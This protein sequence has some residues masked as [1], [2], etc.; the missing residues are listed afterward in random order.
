MDSLVEEQRRAITMKSSSIALHHRGHS[1]TVIDSPGH[2]DF[3]SEVSTVASLSDGALILVDA[4]EGV[5]IQ[6]HAVL[7]QAWID[8]LTQCLVINKID[9]LIS[10]LAMSPSEVYV[11]LLR[12]VSEVN[13]IVSGFKSV[14]YLNDVDGIVSGPSGA[15]DVAFQEI[16]DDEELMFQP[17]KG[18]VAFKALWGPWYFNH[19][20]RKIVGENGVAGLRMARPMFVEFVLEPVWSLYQVAWK[21]REEAEAMG[22]VKAVMSHW[23]PVHEAILSMVI[24][25][26]PDPI[27]AQLYRISRL[28]PKRAEDDSSVPSR[29]ELVRRSLKLVILGLK[30]LVLLLFRK[31]LL[32]LGKHFRKAQAGDIVAIRGLGQH[33]LKTATPSSTKNCWP[34]SG[35][36]FQ[37]SP[38]LKVAIEPSYSADM[39]ALKKGLRLLNADPFV[40]V[41]ES[42]RGEQFL[43]AAGEV[44]LERRIKDLKDRFARVGFV[45]SKPLVSFKETILG[46]EST[47]ENLKSFL[48]S[49]EYVEKAT[50]DGRCVVRV[51]V[52]R[53]PPSQTKVIDE[54][55][56]ILADILA[57]KAAQNKSSDVN[58]IETLRKRMME[59][60]ESDVLSSGETD[61]DRAEKCKL[62]WQKLLKRIWALGPCCVG[63]N[64]LLTPEIKGQGTDSS[65]LIRGSSHVSEI[66]G[67]VDASDNENAA[68]ETSSE[69]TEAHLQT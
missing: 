20:E 29:A 30:L 46:D 21:E 33:I 49:T 27:A 43:S 59:A 3:C 2:I 1:I 44:Y 7:R 62:M 4:V 52:L 10:E 16:E 28:L 11:R 34:L 60:V 61:K 45:V 6:T 47:L 58:P 50:Q 56:N 53:L 18:N 39:G 31:C 5:H 65:V 25:C 67:L 41:T 14:K 9:R 22:M 38:T 42:G 8:K 36:S 55:S 26:M 68:A 63:P 54:S 35:M 19:K 64:I 15:N 66:L 37:V 48:A 12:I 69:V 57:G 32:S 40:E 23:L 13:N 24:T 51:K 17:Q